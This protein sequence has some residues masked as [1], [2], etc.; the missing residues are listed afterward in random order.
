MQFHCKM[1]LKPKPEMLTVK[2]VSSLISKQIPMLTDVM[3]YDEDF[4]SNKIFVIDAG[5]EIVNNKICVL[6]ESINIAQETPTLSDDMYFYE[7]S[8]PNKLFFANQLNL[9]LKHCFRYFMWMIRNDIFTVYHG[10]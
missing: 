1:M 7:D 6:N 5:T 3:H 4:N 8:Q 10:W 9:N 2:F